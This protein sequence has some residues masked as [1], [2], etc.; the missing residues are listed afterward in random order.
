M[1]RTIFVSRLL[2]LLAIVFAVPAAA[3]NLREDLAALVETPAVAG[4]EQALGEK[5]RERARAAGYALEQDNL[6]TLYVTLGRGTPHRLVVAPVDEPGYIVSHI[7]DDGY[8]RV[9]RLPQSGVHPLFEQLHAAQPVVI[10]TREGR[11]ISGVVAGLST[12]LQGGRQNPPR[13]NHPDE[14]YVDIGAAS[15]E[16]VR[17]AG[18]SLLDPI[19]LERRL[20]A[21]GF[22]KVTAPYLG[23]RFGAA[24]LLE[25]LRRLD[26]TRLR[27]T[28][29]IAFLAQQWTNARGLDRLTQHI[30]ADE[31]V[32][33]GRLR[34]RGTGPG[35]V[36]EPGAGVLLAVERAGAEPVGFA[37]EMAALAAAHNIPLRPVP[38]A[39]LPRASYTGGPELPARVVHLAIPIAWPVTPAEVLDV[40]DAEQLTN[41]LTAY[42]LGEVKAGPTGTV[43][44]SR[45]EQFV[46]PTRAPS[47][48][49]LLRWLV[50]TCGVSG[51]EGPV[52]ERIAELLPPWARPETDDA[53]N[54]LLRIG[55]APAGSRVPRIAFVAHMDEIGYVVESIAPD[56]RLVVRSRGGGIL[57]FFAGH[58][59]QVHTAHGPRAAVMELPAGWE[60]PGFDW[61]RGPAQVLRVDVG[62]RTPE[63]VAEL[64]IRVGDSLTVPKKY[65]PLFG[66]RASGRSF[67]D[68]VG[69]AALIA[70]AW[71]LGPN[72]AGRE[73]LLAWVTEEEVGL[74]GAFALAT[75]LAQQGR[76]PDYV[77]AVD[78][79][80]SSDSPLEEKRFGYGQVGK[81]FVIRA[82]D[83]SNI[84]RRELVDRIVALAQR[85]SIPVQ[86]GVTGGGNDGAAFLRYGTVDIPIGW[87]LRYSHSPGEVI[88][89]RDAEALARIVAVLTREW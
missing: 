32:Y 38:A 82:V 57:Q 73:I 2:I 46:R 79:F 83:N 52:R 4:Y 41:L 58:A 6:G 7:T 61:P 12:H 26:R 53:G 56:G 88:D 84:V 77:F 14:V 44:S 16:D 51:H 3:Q 20:L 65:R 62:A 71:E 34:P 21:M 10:H 33:I 49:E 13:V 67:D 17:R 22:G 87:P 1:S 85:N 54:L 15:A 9:Q 68:R 30:R 8:L 50:E 43:R 25:L 35:T 78:T 5:I 86:F 80:V 19:A 11:W 63:Q 70:A 89:V 64:G 72:L 40:A 24:A 81:G 37:A 31:L 45:E 23:D 18:V 74:R 42:A 47:M 55:G 27:G 59:L 76:A 29:T 69:S 39:P 66:T 28:L 36:P 60:E 75:R 48:T